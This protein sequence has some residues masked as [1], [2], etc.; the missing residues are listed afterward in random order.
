LQ[1]KK[2]TSLGA[3]TEKEKPITEPSIEDR[4]ESRLISTSSIPDDDH[5][6]SYHKPVR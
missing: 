4:R 6:N 1:E 3:T 5:G 2:I